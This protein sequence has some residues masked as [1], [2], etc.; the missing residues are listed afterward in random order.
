MVDALLLEVR[1]QTARAGG[2]FHVFII[3]GYEEVT[4]P[5]LIICEKGGPRVCWYNAA[6]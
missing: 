1:R 4:R 6:I 2:Q 3:P 5:V